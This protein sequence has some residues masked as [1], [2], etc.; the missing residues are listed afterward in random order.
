MTITI[1]GGLPFEWYIFRTTLLNNNVI[2]GFEELMA[3]CIQKETRMEEQ[4]IPALRG[5]PAAFS[6][7]AKRRNN[8]GAKSK[9]KAGPKGGR[10]GICYN[11]NKMG[12]YARECPDKRDSHHDDDQNH[13]QVNQ[14]NGNSNCR[15]KRNVENQGRGQLFKKARNSKYESN[16]VNNKQ[17]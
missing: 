1:L 6:S 11:C 2:P 17:D 4:K 10:K 9:R 7:H 5:N 14:R 3:R 12:Y 8:S 15:G 13:S 16:V